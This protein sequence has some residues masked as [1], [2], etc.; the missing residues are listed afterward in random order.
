MKKIKK[1]HLIKP[2]DLIESFEDCFSEVE[3]SGIDKA[4]NII[5]NV[6]LF[7]TSKSSNGR[8]YSD[9]AITSLASFAEGAKCFLDH[10]SSSE[11]KERDGVRSVRD[12][13]GT[14][15]G[16]YKKGDKVYANLRVREA[17]FPLFR[18][19]ATMNP[20]G[21][22]MSINSRV[23]VFQG[24][25]GVENVAD[26]DLLRSVDCVASAATTQNLWESTP[27]VDIEENELNELCESTEQKVEEKFNVLMAEEGVLQSQLDNRKIRNEIDSVSYL[28]QD[29]INRIL[30][31]DKLSVQD[32]KSKVMAVFE[33]LDVEVK[34]RLANIKEAKEN[35]E[36]DLTKLK[37]EHPDLVQAVLDEFKQ[38]EEYMKLQSKLDEATQTINDLKSKLEETEKAITD[39]GQE[40]EDLKSENTTLKAELDKRE[41]SEKLAAKKAMITEA[42]NEAKLPKE[43]VTDI[44][45]ETLMRLEEKTV[46]DE[47]VT[48]E[49]QVKVY[50]EDRKALVNKNSGRI[51][52]SGDEFVDTITESADDEVEPKK[53]KT[54]K[55]S[56]DQFIDDLK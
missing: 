30:M 2:K 9:K 48:V 8:I 14:F 20:K 53:K 41:V 38:A 25:D 16:A 4:N 19:I 11:L 51:R 33:D 27:E 7:G 5:R 28:A 24:E 54:V 3:E 50:I 21:V 23:K 34:K 44:F 49:E 56:A 47:T 26:I 40:L 46:G 35:E 18:D 52:N 29:L 6:C 45:M 39:K 43:A 1:I 12:F 31:D 13:A 36:M 55:E 37:T 22:G 42:L 15:Q 17:F 32:K 10:P